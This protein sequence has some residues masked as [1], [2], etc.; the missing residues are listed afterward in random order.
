[1]VPAVTTGPDHRPLT[2]EE[3]DRWV[4]FG[5][6]WRTVRVGEGEATVELCTCTDEAVERRET[7]DPSV[8]AR[9]RDPG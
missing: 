7:S 2:I 9:L 5:G 4:L 6:T 8:I 1:L 3:L